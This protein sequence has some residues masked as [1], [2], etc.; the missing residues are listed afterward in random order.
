VLKDVADEKDATR[1]AYLVR[2]TERRFA[3][4]AEFSPARYAAV[5]RDEVFGDFFNARLPSNAQ[6][7]RGLINQ[8]IAHFI[9]DISWLRREKMFDLKTKTDLELVQPGR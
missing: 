8:A 2:V 6:H 5:L 3:S 7:R 1:S 9:E 4:K